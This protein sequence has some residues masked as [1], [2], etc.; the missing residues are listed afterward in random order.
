[1]TQVASSNVVCLSLGH[2]WSRPRHEGLS[3]CMYM[4][5]FRVC[6]SCFPVD[7]R[8]VEPLPRGPGRSPPPAIQKGRLPQRLPSHLSPQLL[9]QLY[10]LAYTVRTI[11]TGIAIRI[12]LQTYVRQTTQPPTPST[13]HSASNLFGR[14]P[15]TVQRSS[16]DFENPLFKKAPWALSISTLSSPRRGRGLW[17]QPQTSQPVLP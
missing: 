13:T 7:P 9:R 17:K 2:T 12:P 10:S 1:M 6:K 11:Y 14:Q 5:N 8:P 16:S 15:P 4:S 3:V